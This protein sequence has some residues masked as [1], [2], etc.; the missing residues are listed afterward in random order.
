MEGAEVKRTEKIIKKQC[1]QIL[2]GVKTLGG[3]RAKKRKACWSQ[4]K[5]RKYIKG[6]GTL[7]KTSVAI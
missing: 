7:T 6:F 1:R 3:K 4:T 5:P 2:K